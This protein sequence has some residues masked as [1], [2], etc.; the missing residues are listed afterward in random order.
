MNEGSV[1]SV[2][3]SPDGKTIAAGFISH[4]VGGGVVLW[5]VA[6]RRRLADEPLPVKEGSVRCVAFSPDGK[7]IAAGFYGVGPV[8]RRQRGGVVLWDVAARKRLADEPLPVK[9][10]SVRSVAFSPDGKTI[11]AGMPQMTGGERRRGAVGR[12]RARA[13]GGRAASR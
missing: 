12:G 10:G 5:D 13:P 8:E 4:G 6:A 9:E 7:T 1:T 3:F 2:A 11:A